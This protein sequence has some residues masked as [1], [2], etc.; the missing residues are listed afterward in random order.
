MMVRTQISLERELHRRARERAQEL[1]VSL[2]ELARRALERE[3]G[4]VADGGESDLTAI[5]ALGDSGGSDVARDKDRY[6][7]EAT[8]RAYERKMGRRADG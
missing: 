3:L 7:A 2:A 1:G 5:F 6:L 8:Q 4:E